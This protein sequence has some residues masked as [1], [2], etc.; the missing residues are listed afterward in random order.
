MKN[1]KSFCV[2]RKILDIRESIWPHFFVQIG[3]ESITNA[4][5]DNWLPIGPLSHRLSYRSIHRI[6]FN[7][8]SYVMGVVNNLD[9]CW[10]P[11]W[12]SSVPNLST[13][14][15]PQ[16]QSDACDKVLWLNSS[17]DLVLFVVREIWGSLDGVHATVDWHKH[18]WFKGCIPKHSFC[19]WLVVIFG[20]PFRT[21]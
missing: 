11:D 19:M 6:G 15:I 9:G 7:A 1:P 3:D 21:V 16:I 14:N 4:W 10:P 13:F 12:N 5:E 18:V 8:N 17:N 20:F 2:W